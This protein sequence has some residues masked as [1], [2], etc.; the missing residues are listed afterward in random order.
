M[1]LISLSQKKK[2]K[3]EQ[4]EKRKYLIFKTDQRLIFINFALSFVDYPFC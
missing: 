3:K 4:K 1:Y 2:K